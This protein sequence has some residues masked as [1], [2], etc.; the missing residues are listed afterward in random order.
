MSVF[1]IFATINIELKNI[2]ELSLISNR[3]SLDVEKSIFF[4]SFIQPKENETP[5]VLQKRKVKEPGYG[6][7]DV[8]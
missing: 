1:K 7:N 3:L 4:F 5:L 6:K 8:I 2:N